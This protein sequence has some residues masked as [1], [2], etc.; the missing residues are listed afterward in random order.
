[1]LGAL[2]CAVALCHL[3]VMSRARYHVSAGPQPKE[4]LDDDRARVLDTDELIDFL[5]AR[6]QDTVDEMSKAYPDAYQV[7]LRSMPLSI[8][9]CTLPS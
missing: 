9:L 6:T 2:L 5:Q 7:L 1:M 4:Q 8:T 3:G